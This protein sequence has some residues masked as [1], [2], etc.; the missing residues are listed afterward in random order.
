M[1]T[2]GEITSIVAL[3][4]A[5]LGGTILVLPLLGKGTGYLLIPVIALYFGVLSGYTTYLMVIHL[6]ECKS[7]KEAV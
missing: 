2:Q 6:G 4:N 1:L 3:V 5:M 7:I